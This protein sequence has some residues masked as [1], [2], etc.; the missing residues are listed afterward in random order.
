[1]H[2]QAINSEEMLDRMKDD[3]YRLHRWDLKTGLPTAETLEKLGLTELA[4]KLKETRI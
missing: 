3:Y 2:G 4:G 1:M